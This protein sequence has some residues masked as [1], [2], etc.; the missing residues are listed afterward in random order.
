MAFL[1]ARSKTPKKSRS[2][3]PKNSRSKTRKKSHSKNPRV[4]SYIKHK[5]QLEQII[6][7]LIETA[8]K[9]NKQID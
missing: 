5:Q 7:N 4:K 6:K 2:K 3:T 1:T 8:K 9:E